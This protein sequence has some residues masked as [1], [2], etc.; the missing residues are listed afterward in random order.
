MGAGCVAVIGCVGQH[1]LRLQAL[2]QGKGFWSVAGLSAGGNKVPGVAQGFDAGMD[3][4]ADTAAAAPEALGFGIPFFWPAECWCARTTVESS[5]TQSNLGACKDS[6]RRS[7]TPLLASRRK[8]VHTV[9]ERPKR[10]GRSAYGHPV[11]I[12]QTIAFTNK[13]LSLAVTPH[14]VVLPDKS[15]AIT[16]HWRSV[17]S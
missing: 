3:F 11:R 6:N 1:F 14:S 7:H 2:Q 13:R 5:T 17:V 4:G 15:G 12:I 10:S 9:L 8:R 16:S